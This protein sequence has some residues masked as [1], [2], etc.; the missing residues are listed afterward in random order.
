MFVLKENLESNFTQDVQCTILDKDILKLVA[1][2]T[3]TIILFFRPL[4]I[5]S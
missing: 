5:E 1:F 4:M 2:V 3:V